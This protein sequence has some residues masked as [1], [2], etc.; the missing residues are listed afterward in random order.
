MGT[1]SQLEM[2]VTCFNEGRFADAVEHFGVVEEGDPGYADA[3]HGLGMVA[4]I[5]GELDVALELVERAVAFAPGNIFYLNSLGEVLRMRGDFSAAEESLRRALSIDPE[6]AQAHNNLGMLYLTQGLF[7]ESVLEFNRAVQLAPDLAMAY[8][9]MGIALKEMNQLAGAIAAHRQA[10]AISP[11]F[12]EA[13]V[14]LAIALLL[15]GQLAEGFTEYEWRLRPEFTPSRRFDRPLWNG[16]IDAEGT[17]L[18]HTEQGYGDVIQFV[19]YLPFIAAEGM[20]VILQCP[21]ELQGLLQGVEG[22]SMTYSFDD[23]LPDFDAHIPLLSLPHLFKTDLSKIPA[24][25]PYLFASF[26]KSQAWGERLAALG[27]TIKIGLRWAGNPNN[28]HDSGRSCP[29]ALFEALAGMPQ[30]T[31]VSLQNSPL[32]AL[33]KV[34][35]ERLGLVDVS[36]DL[37]DFSDTAALVSR[38]DLVISVDT[39]VL[40]LAGALGKSAWALLKYAPHWPWLLEREDSPWYPGLYLFRQERSGDWAGV[41]KLAA[42]MLH[43]VMESIQE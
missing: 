30:V 26:E 21:A 41:L 18:V 28:T 43:G 4:W 22:V 6:Y 40:H 3:L 36:A 37:R 1:K 13:H 2:G 23:A 20:R 12:V 19:R 11:D 16:L 31:F 33:E 25:V 24:N 34:S 38:L 7:P 42:V 29:L 10:T 5:R 39:A 9:N 8:F 14:N 32:T 35:A 27:D 17:L 15:E